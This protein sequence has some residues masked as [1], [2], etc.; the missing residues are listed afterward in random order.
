MMKP[1]YLPPSDEHRAAMQGGVGGGGF[2]ANA[3]MVGWAALTCLWW[4][5]VW[6]GGQLHPTHSR[7]RHPPPPSSFPT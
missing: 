1:Y 4:A 3:I 6:A 7:L 2:P 5:G